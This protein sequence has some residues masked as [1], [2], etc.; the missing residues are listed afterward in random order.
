MISERAHKEKKGN[1]TRYNNTD[2]VRQGT[3]QDDGGIEMASVEHY[4]SGNSKRS[5]PQNHESDVIGINVAGA[6]LDMRVIM[7]TGCFAS[8]RI[9]VVLAPHQHRCDKLMLR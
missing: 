4:V 3:C 2:L 5:A 9:G 6:K 1:K 7:Q 8:L